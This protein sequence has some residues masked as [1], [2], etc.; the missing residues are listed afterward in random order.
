MYP[1]KTLKPVYEL[2]TVW[3][4]TLNQALLGRQPNDG[5]VIRDAFLTPLLFLNFLVCVYCVGPCLCVC[6]LFM[7]QVC[8]LKKKISFRSYVK[9]RLFRTGFGAIES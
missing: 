4:K 9:A 8:F 5:G 6:I 7:F 1:S 3:L 2:N